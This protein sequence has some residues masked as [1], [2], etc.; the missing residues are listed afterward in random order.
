MIKL[1]SLHLNSEYSLLQSTIK[2][3]KLIDLA[4]DNGLKELVIT[5]R[6]NMYGVADFIF[7][8]RKAGIKPIIGIDLDVEQYRFVLIAKNYDGYKELMRLSSL[9]EK[10]NEI[11]I[12][13]INDFDLFVIDHPTQGF[14]SK[15][16][17]YPKFT[18]FFLG[19][20]EGYD[21]NVV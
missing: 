21:A 6:N 2:I 10:G 7:K 20:T 1:P 16:N 11:T 5:D 12:D 8:T 14:V 9:K 17:R 15:E 13:E 3:D 18:N 4:K 19:S